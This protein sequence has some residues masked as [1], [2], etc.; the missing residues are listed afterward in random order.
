MQQ[1]RNNCYALLKQLFMQIYF[2]KHA[3]VKRKKKVSWVSAAVKCQQKKKK[4][5]SY[6]SEMYFE[7]LAGQV[8]TKSKRLGQICVVFNMKAVSL[9]LFKQ[10]WLKPT[11]TP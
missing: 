6:F 4:T 10:A 8:S 3:N 2:L 7:F 9:H 5:Q 1:G 11:A